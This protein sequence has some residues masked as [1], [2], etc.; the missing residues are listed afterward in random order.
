MKSAILSGVLLVF[1]ISSHLPI[2]TPVRYSYQR[3]GQVDPLTK[4][5]DNKITFADSLFQFLKETNTCIPWDF[6]EDYCF[7]RAHASYLLIKENFHTEVG[8][9]YIYPSDPTSETQ[10]RLKLPSNALYDSARW[11][12]HVTTFLA[13][14]GDTLILDPALTNGP[15]TKAEYLARLNIPLQNFD[16]TIAEGDAY[17][18]VCKPKYNYHDQEAVMVTRRAIN[19][20]RMR[21]DQY[22]KETEIERHYGPCL[23]PIR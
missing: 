14:K 11:N 1:L 15:L 21:R 17:C 20:S 23:L 6:P 13:L 18:T 9:M 19:E 16:I 2:A 5:Q 8:K 7:A 12:G 22:L 3:K 10:L 4:R